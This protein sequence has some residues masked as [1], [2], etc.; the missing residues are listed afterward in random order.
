MIKCSKCKTDS[1][2]HTVSVRTCPKCGRVLES[3][4][5]VRLLKTLGFSKKT[6]KNI[7]KELATAR[8]GNLQK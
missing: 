7:R 4:Q 5:L 6:I 3:K 1:A 8:V 2:G